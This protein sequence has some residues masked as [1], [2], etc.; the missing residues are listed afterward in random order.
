VAQYY[1]IEVEHDTAS[2]KATVLTWRRTTPTEAT[3][4][5]VYCLHTNQDQ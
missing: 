3:H 1:E 5:G 4:P 2:A